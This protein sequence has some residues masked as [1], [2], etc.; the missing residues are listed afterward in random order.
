MILSI[1][2]ALLPARQMEMSADTSEYRDE[3]GLL[4]TSNTC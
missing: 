1:L 3:A 4:L 2:K